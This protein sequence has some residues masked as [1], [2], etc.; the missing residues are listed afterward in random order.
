M[1]VQVYYLLLESTWIMPAFCGTQ[2]KNV[3][4]YHSVEKRN[5]CILDS[6]W[7][8]AFARMTIEKKYGLLRFTYTM[9]QWQGKG[10]LLA[11]RF[12]ELPKKPGRDINLY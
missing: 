3:I 6:T 2:F 5:P 12:G 11:P 7:I 9:T 1:L 10:G 8:L 4:N